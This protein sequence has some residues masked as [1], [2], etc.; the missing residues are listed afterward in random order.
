MALYTAKFGELSGLSRFWGLCPEN[1]A[2]RSECRKR[3]VIFTGTAALILSSE[4]ENSIRRYLSDTGRVFLECLIKRFQDFCFK[5]GF[6]FL[7]GS[8]VF[9]HF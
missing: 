9:Q 3:T 6:L 4:G 5:L 7:L 1:N 2:K 8:S